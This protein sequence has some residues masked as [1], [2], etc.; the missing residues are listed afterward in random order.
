MKQL[1]PH[2][3]GELDHGASTVLVTIL[4]REGSAPRGAG[5]CMLLCPDDR[6][7]GTIGGGLLE[8]TAIQRARMCRN[9]ACSGICEYDLSRDE[10][11]SI[12][13]VCGGKVLLHFWHITEKYQ[14][15]FAELFGSVR[16]GQSA[17]LSRTVDRDGKIITAN[18]L[19][20]AQVSQ[21]VLA[22]DGFYRFIEPITIASRAYVFGGGHV[23]YELVPLLD[24]LDFSPVVFDDRI[25]FASAERFPD[26]Q[27]VIVGNFSDISQQVNIT[28]HDCIVIMTRGHSY[29]HVLLTQALHTEAYYIGLIGSRSKIAHTKSLLFEE[30][31]TE[32]DFARVHTPI[33]LPI[34]AETPAEIAV[35]IAAEMIKI[36]REHSIPLSENN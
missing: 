22:E 5:A 34:L 15:L 13:M 10:A 7:I 31:F 3:L 25:E 6:V 27:K 26:A 29:D 4:H 30:G 14:A 35:S 19:H 33:G 2:I 23:A 32:Q 36:R 17:W 24:R 28:K 9:S 8:H 20:D 12:G 18:V 21:P 1:I 11:G 16:N